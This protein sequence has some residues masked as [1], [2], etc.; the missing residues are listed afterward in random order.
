MTEVLERDPAIM[1]TIVRR[2]REGAIETLNRRVD[3]QEALCVFWSIEHA[4]RDMEAGGFWPE[5]GWKA[6]ERDHEELA[7][8]FGLLETINAGP[9]LAFLEPCPGAE[10]LQGVFEPADL[11]DMLERHLLEDS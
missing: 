9:L 6:I 2:V 8:A 7:Q 10:E 4:E 3:G 5:D 11:V 1:P